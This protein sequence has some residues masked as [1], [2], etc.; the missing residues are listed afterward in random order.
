[1]AS[2]GHTGRRIVLG[3]TLNT[4]TLMKTDDP[5]KKVLSKFMILCWAVFLAI[6][7]SKWPVGHGLDAPAEST[8]CRV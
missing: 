5:Q 7:G 1:M 8:V 4:Q 2:L 6:L 3:H